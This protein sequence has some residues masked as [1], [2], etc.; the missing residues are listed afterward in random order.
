MPVNAVVSDR[1]AN[2]SYSSLMEY[3]FPLVFLA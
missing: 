1:T 2:A 3:V